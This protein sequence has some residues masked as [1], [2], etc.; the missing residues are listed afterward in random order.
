RRKEIPKD[1]EHNDLLVP[2]FRQGR[3]V[4][5]PPP[6]QEIRRRTAEQLEG[7]HGGIKRFVNPHRYPVGLERG[8]FDLKTR[9]ILKARGI[10]EE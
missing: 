6:L 2:V 1:T 10:E 8:L 7:F 4:Y 5:D 9:L 3:R